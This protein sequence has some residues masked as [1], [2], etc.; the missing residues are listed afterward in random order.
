MTMTRRRFYGESLLDR[1]R[2][3]SPWVGP[4]VSVRTEG[5]NESRRGRLN[6]AQDAVL[7]RN[8][9]DD[10]SRRD[11]WQLPGGVPRALQSKIFRH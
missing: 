4:Y 8:S 6:L 7:G 1:Q 3:S 10:K 11:G 2:F 9:K 5:K